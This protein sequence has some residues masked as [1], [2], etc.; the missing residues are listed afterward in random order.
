MSSERIELCG[1]TLD[2]RYELIHRIGV[3]GTGVVFEGRRLQ[4]GG[5]VAIKTLRPCFVDHPDLGRRLSR[6]AEVGRSDLHPGI[7]RVLDEGTLSDGSPFIVMPLMQGE[8][9]AELLR[10]SQRL[11]ADELC[12]LVSRVAAVLHQV[13]LAGYVHRD[14]KPEHVLLSREAGGKLLVHLLDFGVCASRDA[15]SDEKEREVGKV[16][17]T[18]TYASPEQA[19]G[20]VDIDGRADLFSVGI[21]MFESISGTLP[22]RGANISKLLLS[23]MRDDAP[24]LLTVAPEADPCLAALVARLL[25]RNPLRRMPSARALGRALLNHVGDAHTAERRL[26]ARLRSPMGARE[27]TLRRPAM[28]R[29]TR[30]LMPQVA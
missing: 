8:S 22:F 7:V 19:A 3:G 4:D 17:G 1:S 27:A 30:S 2:G 20:K 26:S 18:P 5:A 21:L 16:F 9:L 29:P 28:T 12:A 24:A 11:P 10:R 13:H 15:P 23:I 25:E 14:V 6:E